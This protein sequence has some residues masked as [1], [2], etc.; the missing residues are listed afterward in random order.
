MSYRTVKVP[1]ALSLEA[2]S[3]LEATIMDYSRVY[4]RLIQWYNANQTTNSIRAQRAIYQ[5]LR[6]EQPRLPVQFLLLAA[7]SAAGALRSFHSNYPKRKWSKA[8][9]YRAQRVPLDLRTMNLRGS[10]FTFSTIAK[11]QRA[12]VE[13]PEWFTTRY[14][15]RRLQSATIGLSKDG[16]AVLA[17]TFKVES[18]AIPAVGE[19]V[20]LDRGI[21][22]LVASSSGELY[23]GK[24]VRAKRRQQLYIRRSLQAKGTKAAKRRLTAL[25]GKEARFSRDVNH[26]VSKEL[27]SK[28][29]VARYVLEDLVAIGRRRPEDKY[30]KKSSKRKSDWAHA[31][32]LFFLEYKCAAA[33]VEVVFVNPAWTSQECSRCGYRSKSNRSSGGFC[34]RKCGHRAHADLNAAQNI[35]QKWITSASPQ[36]KQLGQDPGHGSVDLWAEEN[37]ELSVSRSAQEALSLAAENKRRGSAPASY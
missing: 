18:E 20:G 8:P 36:P 26:R 27:A 23:G 32:L 31:Q 21:I 22:N 11:R 15:E 3:A 5:Q 33:G 16:R 1:L 19:T 12:L 37:P 4:S 14:S 17:L 2:R 34:C 6:S 35:L 24:A 28:S 7:R 25:A 29:G 10:L 13:L 9:V 30:G